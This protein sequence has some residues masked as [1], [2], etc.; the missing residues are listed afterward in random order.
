MSGGSALN[1]V[2]SASAESAELAADALWVLGATAVVEETAGD[3]V[4]LRAA[5]GEDEELLRTLLGPLPFAWRLERVDLAVADTWRE[6]ACAVEVDPSMIIVPHWV[7]APRTDHEFRLF[8]EPGA[9]FGLGNHPTTLAS[10]RI[11]GRLVRD[12]DTVLDVGTG[13]G[14][15]AIAAV[16]RGARTAHGT[17]INPASL[18]IVALNAGLNA[19]SGRVTVGMESLDDLTGPY[20][21]VVANILAPTLIELAEHLVRLTQRTLV[22][23]GLLADRYEHVVA[24][25]APL[26]IAAIEHV[27][28]WVAIALE[29]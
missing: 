16:C 24:A 2:V 28:G 7:D 20:S 9:T 15:L 18:E 21:I 14:V 27:D 23:S 17:D 11:L 25:L 6:F 1:V 13:S 22:I 8:I 10:L 19:V 4:E 29:R 12:G 3:H 5:L 26:H